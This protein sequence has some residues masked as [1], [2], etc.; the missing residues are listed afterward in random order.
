MDPMVK[1][2]M[3]KWPH[4]PD[5]YGWLGLD[6]RGRWWMRDD[7]TQQQGPFAG[8]A[9]TASSKGSLLQHERLI[10]FIDRN[11]EVDTRGCWYFQ[12]GPQR[13]FVELEKAPYIWRLYSPHSLTAHTGLET[14][15]ERVYV[16]EDGAVYAAGPAGCG[17]VHTQDMHLAGEWVEAGLW[18][19]QEKTLREIQ[20]REAYVLSPRSL[21]G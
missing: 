19:P 5:C 21:A 6:A 8:P 1:A 4:V 20:Q 16:A 2:A 18:S 10:A 3:A 9:S 14:N 7:Q 15:C 11:Y 13:V 12:N 17:L